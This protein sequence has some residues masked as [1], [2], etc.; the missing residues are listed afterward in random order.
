[1]KRAFVDFVNRVP[2]YGL[3]VLCIDHPHVQSI[4]P[5]VQKRFVT[6]GEAPQADY[7]ARDIRFEGFRT[8]YVAWRRAEELGRVTI[9]MPGK[10]NVLNSLADL[11]VADFLGVPF[12]TFRDAL[13][14]FQGV[15]RRFTVRGV[16]RGVMVVDD[17]G[18]HPMEVRATLAGARAGFPGRRIVAAFQ[19]HRFTRTRDLFDE[20]ACAFNDADGVVLCDVFAAG[21]PPIAGIESAKLAQAMRDHGH[22]D[23]TYIPRRDDIATHLGDVA[24][25]GDIVITL[26]AGDIQVTCVE[27]LGILRGDSLS[28]AAT[29]LAMP[30]AAVGV[31]GL[32]AHAASPASKGNPGA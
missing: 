19:P 25:D 28:A 15:Q 5:Q 1:M 10:H 26:G 22:R 4:L 14:S 2:F 21:E 27:L 16:E 6:Y 17:F 3:A 30:P 23:V 13:A 7:R 31:G 18:H 20:F 24:R 11:A 29:T 9:S 32:I 8:S 12:A